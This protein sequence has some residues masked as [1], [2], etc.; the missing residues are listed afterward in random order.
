[1]TGFASPQQTAALGR[2]FAESIMSATCEVRALGAGTTT[3]PN[4][5]EIITPNGALIYAGKCHVQAG[6]GSA[7]QVEGGEVFTYDFL[8]SLP[9]AVSGVSGGQLVTVT[10]SPDPDLVGRVMEVQRVDR[11]DFRTARRLQCNG[12]AT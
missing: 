10:S 9:A 8:V 1:M 6:G 7:A 2:A 12:R 4:T 5:G 11:G 3:D